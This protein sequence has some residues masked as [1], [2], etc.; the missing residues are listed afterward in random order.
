M[1][2]YLSKKWSR[3]RHLLTL[4]YAAVVCH[5]ETLLQF[6]HVRQRLQVHVHTA[7]VD[8]CDRVFPE[9]VL[10]L[11]SYEDLQVASHEVNY[12]INTRKVT[13]HQ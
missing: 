4:L 2:V 5:L 12:G 9:R 3:V 8:L 13:P 7:K 1:D 10:F 11:K 6:H